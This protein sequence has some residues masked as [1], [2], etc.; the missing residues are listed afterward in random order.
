MKGHYFAVGTALKSSYSSPSITL[1]CEAPLGTVY[2]IC[3]GHSLVQPDTRLSYG[4][5]EEYASL[6]LG[7]HT[8]TAEDNLRDDRTSDALDSQSRPAVPSKSSHE[9]ILAQS[10]GEL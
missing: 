2:I 6:S 8:G 4:N 9:T 10:V 5:K 7:A 3:C 1:A